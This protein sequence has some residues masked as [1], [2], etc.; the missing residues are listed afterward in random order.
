MAIDFVMKYTISLLS[1]KYPTKKFSNFDMQWVSL[2][3]NNAI[4]IICEDVINLDNL[5]STF[6][7]YEKIVDEFKLALRL[8]GNYSVSFT[9]EYAQITF[10]EKT[11]NIHTKETIDGFIKHIKGEASSFSIAG[12]PPRVVSVSYGD[13]EVVKMPEAVLCVP[14]DLERLA[15]TIILANLAKGWDLI[16]KVSFLILEEFESLVDV[17]V[18][19][20]LKLTRNFVFS[21]TLY[22]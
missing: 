9:R 4:L 21:F 7:K 2:A 18:Y 20:E 19:K 5:Y 13:L 15:S 17:S 8:D 12:L 14:L 11:Y 1:K 6:I 3:K 16:L 22:K 10:D